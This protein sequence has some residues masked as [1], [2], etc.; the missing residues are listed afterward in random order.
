MYA[1]G[2]ESRRV[3][4]LPG[5]VEG[6]LL[7]LSTLGAVGAA[8]LGGMF[9]L[10]AGEGFE[11]GDRMPPPREEFGCGAEEAVAADDPVV[12]ETEGLAGGVGLQS[13]AHLAQ[14]HRHRVD[15][16][17]VHAASASIRRADT[18]GGACFWLRRPSW[19]AVIASCPARSSPTLARRCPR[20][21]LPST[22]PFPVVRRPVCLAV[23]VV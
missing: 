12:K 4:R 18:V 17:A 15:V 5:C 11:R 20:L 13:E 23:L 19:P 7:A 16:D 22:V 9:L 10:V 2:E 3:G 14:L 21:P 1:P 8:Q 6:L